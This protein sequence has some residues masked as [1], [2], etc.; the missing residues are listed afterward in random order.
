M[1]QVTRRFSSAA[2]TSTGRLHVGG[3]ERVRERRLPRERRRRAGALEVG[4]APEPADGHA[5][6]PATPRPRAAADAEPRRG[7]GAACIG[8]GRA[9]SIS[10]SGMARRAIGS[11]AS[12]NAAFCAADSAT[13]AASDGSRGQRLLDRRRRS[14]GELAVGVGVEIGVG[15]KADGSRQLP[16]VRATTHFTTLSETPAVRPRCAAT[17]RGRATDATSP[18][19]PGSPAPPQSPRSAAPR[20]RRAA[21]PRAARP[22]SRPTC[23]TVCISSTR[24]V[25][26][27]RAPGT[28]QAAPNSPSASSETL[29]AS[30]RASAN[31]LTRTLC[32][33]VN[34]HARKSVPACH[35]APLLPRSRERVLHEVVGAR[36]VAGQHPRV[37][38]QPRNRGDQVRV[39]QRGR[40][41]ADASAERA[42]RPP[43]P[44]WTPL[45]RDAWRR[46]T[47]C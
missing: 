42:I 17:S 13:R 6:A 31:W 18:S 45:R 11:S 41:Q 37:A 20:P 24:V 16:A 32:M 12:R 28:C 46:A 26:A 5:R 3:V 25:A 38:A 4:V 29:P 1:S 40:R 14:G 33:I 22:A 19:R 30:R 9:A 47:R 39:R 21:A 36:R 2:Q 15:D 27:S 8:A 35:S 34:S 10:R 7:R 43:S 23:S 44:R